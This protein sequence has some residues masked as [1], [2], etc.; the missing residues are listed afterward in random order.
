MIGLGSDKNGG[1]RDS[2]MKVERAARDLQSF[3]IDIFELCQL[4]VVGLVAPL[5]SNFK[6][7]LLNEHRVIT[8]LIYHRV[9]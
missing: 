9:V 8:P 7:K 3:H 2:K 1:D 5:K 4:H 6:K